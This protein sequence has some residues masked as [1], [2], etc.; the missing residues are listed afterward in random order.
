MIKLPRDSFAVK[1]DEVKQTRLFLGDSADKP[2][3]GIIVLASPGLQHYEGCSVMFRETHAEEIKIQEQD[4]LFFRD[5][6]S[7]IYYVVE[8]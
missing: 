5:F 7:S 4:L 1:R 8:N 2:N 6:D 3:T